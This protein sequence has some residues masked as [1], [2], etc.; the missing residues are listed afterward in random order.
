MHQICSM[1]F[2]SATAWAIRSCVTFR[3]R[4][5]RASSADPGGLFWIPQRPAASS[6]P[7]SGSRSV[8]LWALSRKAMTSPLETVS[9]TGADY[10][11]PPADPTCVVLRRLS[12]LRSPLENARPKYPRGRRPSLATAAWSPVHGLA[13]LHLDERLAS[14]PAGDVA[15]RP[16]CGS[17]AIPSARGGLLRIGG[18]RRDPSEYSLRA[19]RRIIPPSPASAGLSVSPIRGH[20]P[21]RSGHDIR[22]VQVLMAGTTGVWGSAGSLVP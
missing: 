21:F 19:W 10:R 13:F 8:R 12:S 14:S 4:A 17:W 20:A 3:T 2:S 16:Q 22:Q 6:N 9:A 5:C 1:L 15:W 11:G 7:F 18:L